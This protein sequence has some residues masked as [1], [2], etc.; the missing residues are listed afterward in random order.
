MRDIASQAA[1]EKSQLPRHTFAAHCEVVAL[2]SYGLG[3]RD[4]Q[5]TIIFTNYEDT[6]SDSNFGLVDCE[7]SHQRYHFQYIAILQNL[8]VV[9]C[10]VLM[11]LHVNLQVALACD[12]ELIC[13]RPSVY[14]PRASGEER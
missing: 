8:T 10:P 11:S 2:N 5:A 6:I 9:D 4:C 12:T 14:W 3:G 7:T 1:A 13:K